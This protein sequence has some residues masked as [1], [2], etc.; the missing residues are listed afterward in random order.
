MF[1]LLFQIL[2]STFI[3]GNDKTSR[4]EATYKRS[5]VPRSFP[6]PDPI[7]FVQYYA[8]LEPL[9][10]LPNHFSTIPESLEKL[11]VII[12]N[13]LKNSKDVVFSSSGSSWSGSIIR[14]SCHC[15]F[16]FCIYRSRKVENLYIIEGQ[17]VEGDGFLFGSLY[18]GVKALFPPT[19]QSTSSS[20]SF[21]HTESEK[22]ADVDMYEE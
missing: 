7:C 14:T 1:Y 4:G 5:F 2:A 20:A 9:I 10:L 19:V 15:A 21:T 13:Y 17:R 16:R 22:M 6:K 12:E 11:S 8:P 3:I 18:Q